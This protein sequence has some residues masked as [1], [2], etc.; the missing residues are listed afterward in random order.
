M[1]RLV[2]I[3]P[4]VLSLCCAIAYQIK[5]SSVA[6]SGLLV[7]SFGFIPVGIFLFA[8]GCIALVITEIILWKK[9]K[10]VA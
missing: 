1:I 3:V 9:N 4:F 10:P 6:E 7:E 2:Y 8:V 5:G